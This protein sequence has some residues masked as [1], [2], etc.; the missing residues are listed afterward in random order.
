MTWQ[1]VYETDAQGV[2][3][4]IVVPALFLL[5]R[6]TRRRPTDTPAA[7]F[8]DAWAIVF[9]I[10][11]IVDPVATGPFVRWLGAGD[12]WL[13]QAILFLVVWLGDFR[14]F[15]LVFGVGDAEHPARAARRAAAWTFV[16]PLSTI[17]VLQLLHALRGELPGVVMW[18][19]YETGFTTLALLL[20]RGMA[21]YPRAVL[22]YAATYYALW[23]AADVLVLAGVDAGWA[24]RIVPNQLYYA[25]FVPFAYARYVA[26]RAS[27]Q[28]T[29]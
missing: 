29:R 6:A 26:T 23:L 20:R 1:A 7:R 4:V 25:F 24:L 21:P 27:A 17:V 13:G 3:A 8:V 9:A 10:E 15:L 14:V 2:W 11:T 12:T 18:I 22:A 16:V 28:A 5:W 19:V